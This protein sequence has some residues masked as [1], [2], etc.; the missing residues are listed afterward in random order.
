MPNLNSDPTW[1]LWVPLFAIA[2]SF[3]ERSDFLHV[4]DVLISKRVV[5]FDEWYLVNENLQKVFNT[6]EQ[7]DPNSTIMAKMDKEEFLR[8]R[9]CNMCPRST[10]YG[11]ISF[12]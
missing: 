8:R 9:D 11:E 1:K 2:A 12:S 5:V 10:D 7:L 4:E 6:V 3:D